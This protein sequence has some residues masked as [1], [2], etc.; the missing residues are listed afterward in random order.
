MFSYNGADGPE[1]KVMHM[2]CSV[3]QVA[4]L[5]AKYAVSDCVLL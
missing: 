3:L 1:T 4:A 2:F 5:E